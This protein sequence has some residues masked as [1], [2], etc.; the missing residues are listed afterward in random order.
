MKKF[1]LFNCKNVLFSLVPK[2]LL[3]NLTSKKASLK[4]KKLNFI[5]TIPL[6]EMSDNAHF[7]NLS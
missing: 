4:E 7:C 5:S 1:L 3:F 6:P 2:S